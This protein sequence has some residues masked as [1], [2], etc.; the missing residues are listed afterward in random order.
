[1]ACTLSRVK[2]MFQRFDSSNV[3]LIPRSELKIIMQ[4]IGGHTF[5]GDGF[6]TLL[7]ECGV[8]L[9]C[10]E[11]VYGDFLERLYSGDRAPQLQEALS[12]QDR[13]DAEAL[14][15]TVSSRIV[16]GI[17]QRDAH[18]PD[19]MK[20]PPQDAATPL[21]A[22]NTC[23]LELL[24]SIFS[25]D[26]KNTFVSPLSISTALAMTANGAR[27]PTRDEILVALSA[28]NVGGMDALNAG[29]Q[30]LT[31][32]L[33]SQRSRV[34]FYVANSIWSRALKASFL[35][36]CAQVYRAE[37]VCDAPQAAPINRWC[38][39][40]T[41]GKIAQ[42]LNPAEPLDSGGAVLVNAIYFKGAWT[43]SFDARQTRASHF[44][45]SSGSRPC[46]MMQA[47]GPD[48]EFLYAETDTYQAAVLPY[49]DDCA[50]SAVVMVPR[51]CSESTLVIDGV[52]A[53]GSAA[54]P[55]SASV[56]EVLAA[57]S[58]DWPSLPSKLQKTKGTLRLPRFEV[59]FEADLKAQLIARGM[60]LACGVGGAADFG[61]MSNA[62]LFIEKVIH[63]TVVE[64]NEEGTE[65][66]AVT[67]VVMNRC[68][69][70]RAAPK[71]IMTCNRPFLFVI[72]HDS[73]N[74]IIF[75]GVVSDM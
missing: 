18:V 1:M 67:A 59:E 42:V 66:A 13:A 16:A 68:M 39:D 31:S 17:N 54:R 11:I 33:A 28:S 23:G 25:K 71:F 26:N 47:T 69:S 5:A 36:I 35:D 56:D 27:G 50:Y 37:A 34:R 9:G 74:A 51:D 52:P 24:R 63:K 38:E 14:G 72:R 61:E 41:K 60:Q 22:V 15:G 32:V 75:A 4:E 57:G 43:T 62:D 3:G 70:P 58:A 10:G 30:S 65:A 21:D 49:G 53:Q 29:M 55:R 48:S 2:E 6:D 73:S 40:R 19:E 44:R 64:V 20:L 12:D 46:Q 45:G 8:E 7:T